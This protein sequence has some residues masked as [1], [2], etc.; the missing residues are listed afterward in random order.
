MPYF[1]L[2]HLP[3]NTRNFYF[4]IF[5]CGCCWQLSHAQKIVDYRKIPIVD[6]AIGLA[7]YYSDWFVGKKTANGEKFSQTKLTCAHN[8]LPFG[9]KLRVTDIKTGNFVIVRVNDRL[10]RNNPRLVDLSKAAAAKLV[11]LRKQGVMTVSVV[12]MKEKPQ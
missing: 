12:V 6:S 11:G 4:L 5:F 2:K 10:H 8:S 7:S 9:T 3:L 1:Y